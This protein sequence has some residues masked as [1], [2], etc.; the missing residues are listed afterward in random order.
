MSNVES[1]NTLFHFT[2]SITYLKS[3]L[4][5]GLYIR[6]SLETYG[7]IL[8]N[9]ESLVLPMTCFCDIPLTRIENHTVKYGEYAI[10][11]S[12]KWG[13]KNKVSPVVYTH[14]NSSTVSILNSII[15]EIEN[16]FDVTKQ[17]K[18][19]ISKRWK[20]DKKTHP[21]K[22]QNQD[23]KV[24]SI[25]YK[26]GDFLSYIKPY[27][28]EGFSNGNRFEKVR[29]Y[30]EREWRFVPLKK[31]VL[32]FELKDSYEEEYYTNPIKRRAINMKLAA[33]M[34]LEFKPSDISFIVVKEDNEIPKMIDDL[35][36]IFGSKA[37]HDELM[38]LNSGLISLEQI[39]NNL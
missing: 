13:L 16:Y 35:R 8:E 17:E 36:K 29:F 15:S 37:T 4:K 39:M 38:I 27:S 21:Y 7:E 32:S 6:Y 31:D 20:L 1:A 5:N 28:G 14:K 12:K 33:K 34:K 11:L 26:F 19:L 10:G 2:G 30:D 18:D 9:S 25:N 23:N 22:N 3:I 24:S